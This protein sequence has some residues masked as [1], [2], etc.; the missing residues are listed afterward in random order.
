MS[1]ILSFYESTRCITI[2][3]QLGSKTAALRYE[4]YEHF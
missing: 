4:R 2:Q 3:G 1:F